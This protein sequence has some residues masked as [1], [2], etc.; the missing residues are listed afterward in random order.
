MEKIDFEAL[1]SILKEN[2]DKSIVLTFHSRGDTDSVSS[3][4][5]LSTYFPNSKVLTPDMITSN[6][7][8]IIKKLGFEETIP[9][10]FDNT[11]DMVVMLDVNNF[12]DCGPF[13]RKLEQFTG[14]IVIIDHHLLKETGK[15]NTYVFNEESYNSAASITYKLLKSLGANVEKKIAKLLLTGIVSDSAELKNVT[16]DTFTQIG[17]LLKIADT[18]YQVL[19]DEM[20]HISDPGSRAKTMDDVRN[21][22]TTIEGEMLLVVGEAHAHA[23]LAA[24]AALRIGAD[25][26]LFRAEN[27]SEVSFSARLRAPLDKKYGIHLGRM[28]KELAPII[29][30]SGGGHPCAAGAYGP[31]NADW[32]KFQ[33]MFMDQIYKR[34][35]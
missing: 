11:A 14:K 35:K 24:D 27:D 19:L 12:E 5:A 21:A 15:D 4:I 2:K 32:R 16:A 10:Q 30:G 33:E 6:S 8:R 29:K 23:N 1:T 22:S 25:F 31:I 7:S 26:S 9:N 17:E 28:M 18:D 20:I 13:A 3:A 34:I